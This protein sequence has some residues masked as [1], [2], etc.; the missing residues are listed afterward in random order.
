M[1]VGCAAFICISVFAFFLII[2]LFYLEDF[3]D[4]DLWMYEDHN[5][6]GNA[7]PPPVPDL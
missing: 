4:L 5:T 7:P 2:I 3:G 1:G 6:A